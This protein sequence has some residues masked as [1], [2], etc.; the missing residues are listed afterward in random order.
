MSSMSRKKR[1]I[2]VPA[3]L[4]QLIPQ[5][6]A[7]RPPLAPLLMDFLGNLKLSWWLAFANPP[8]SVVFSTFT[9]SFF[10]YFVLIFSFLI[11]F[12]FL[13]LI[14]MVVF[15]PPRCTNFGF[16][17]RL[18]GWGL[19]RWGSYFASR[20]SNQRTWTTFTRWPLSFLQSSLE[21]RIGL[22]MPC[23]HVDCFLFMYQAV[24]SSIDQ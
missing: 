11:I 13:I 5:S 19:R 20:G 8:K 16:W 18:R 14:F 17:L 3:A 15:L 6:K 21:L 9:Q 23:K 24:A 1:P 2:L 12:L 7:F 22:H 4:L 10:W